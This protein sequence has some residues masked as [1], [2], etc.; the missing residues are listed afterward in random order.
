M[1][2]ITVSF[3]KRLSGNNAALVSEARAVL[4]RFEAIWR[5]HADQSP[6]RR[7]A[8]LCE[9]VDQEIERVK[10]RVPVPIPCAKG[11]DHCCKFSEIFVTD[12]EAMLL[13][14]HIERLDPTRRAA[15][16][17]R[18]RSS[19][20]RSG[21]GAL[22]PCVLLD[23]GGC[24]VYESRPLCCRGYYSLSEP[25]CREHLNGRA[26]DPPNLAAARVIEFAALDTSGTHQR[27]PYE[28]NSLLRR[29]YSSPEK[30]SAWA[31][32]QATD[33][34]DLVVKPSSPVSQA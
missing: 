17:A 34:A 26:G 25:A 23:A 4:A 14:H 6:P 2:E 28:L 31:A 10:S 1:R 21:G 12:G 30:P 22:S 20:G 32:G 19:D 11:C 7:Q 15:V 27:G 16:V 9:A 33:E 13:A 18:I 8:A 24:S 3:V 5:E 29:I